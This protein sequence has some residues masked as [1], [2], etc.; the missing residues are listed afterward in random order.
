MKAPIYHDVL[1][2]PTSFNMLCQFFTCCSEKKLRIVV[3]SKRSRG[4]LL[5]T[6][7][8]GPFTRGLRNLDFLAQVIPAKQKQWI[9]TAKSMLAMRR[10]NWASLR[11]SFHSQCSQNPTRPIH[12]PRLLSWLTS[13]AV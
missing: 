2:S 3:L 5:S 7:A 9:L 10:V 11:W 6:D 4:D 12:E 1:K 13:S 8:Y